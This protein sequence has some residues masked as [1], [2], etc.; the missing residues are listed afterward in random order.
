MRSFILHLL[1]VSL[2]RVVVG[3]LRVLLAWCRTP[4]SLKMKCHTCPAI[5]PHRYPCGK[6]HSTN[7]SN[8]RPSPGRSTRRFSLPPAACCRKETSR[9]H[10]G[11]SH[12]WANTERGAPSTE[13]FYN[14]TVVRLLG[15]QRAPAA[16]LTWNSP[17]RFVP[18]LTFF[19][20]IFPLEKQTTWWSLTTT[21]PLWRAPAAGHKWIKSGR[22]IPTALIFS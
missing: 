19:A 20:L 15:L 3:R 16:A 22:P 8:W 9:I 11:H 17:S 7:L 18:R 13:Y 1:R 12:V 5:R 6:A 2:S 4:T 21:I 14:R 10:T